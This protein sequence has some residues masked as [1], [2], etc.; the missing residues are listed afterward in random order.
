MK[1]VLHLVEYLELGGIERFLFE[2]AVNK[3]S[4][5]CKYF[6]FAYEMD[7]FTGI[8][9]EI[10]E[11]NSPITIYKKKNGFDF[12]LVYHLYKFVKKNKIE[13]IHTHD[14]GPMEYGVL[15]K[16]L[17]PRL[18][19]IHTQHTSHNLISK[20]QYVKRFEK[21]SAFYKS[22]FF[23]SNSL[24]ED[25]KK[26]GKLSRNKVD[27]IYN[28]IDTSKYT[29]QKKDFNC[30]KFLSVCRISPEK[31]LEYTL[32]S[33]KILKNN[34]IHFSFH[35]YGSGKE[36]EV[37]KIKTLI[38]RLGLSEEVKIMGYEKNIYQQMENYNVFISSS[39]TEGN[40]LSLLEAMSSG[41]LCLCSNIG[42]HKE[43][44]K[45]VGLYFDINS[46]NEL[47]YIINEIANAVEDES[48]FKNKLSNLTYLASSEVQRTFSIKNMFS[49]YEQHYLLN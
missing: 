38:I 44:L 2:F 46:T 45:G 21:F 20:P 4:L 16:V 41:L 25:F 26:Y 10:K 7:D 40:P 13:I 28:G 31:N 42:P 30:L 39:F 24:L 18:K 17:I 43:V 19:I 27:V 14:F 22:I 11:A 29:F 34:N 33:L 1:N 35:I 37:R 36:F 9:N 15:L 49:E 47:A 23:V 32:K 48:L 8:A 5:Q 12:K 3:D 6:F